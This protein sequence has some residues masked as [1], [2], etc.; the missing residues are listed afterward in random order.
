[1]IR[2]PLLSA[3]QLQLLY[4]SYSPLQFCL[5]PLNA[6]TRVLI[7]QLFLFTLID[8]TLKQLFPQRTGPA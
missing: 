3:S 2:L 1:M 6:S 7:A 4:S 8:I 5:S